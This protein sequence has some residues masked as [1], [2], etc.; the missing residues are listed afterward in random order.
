MLEVEPEQLS[1]TS[2]RLPQTGVGQFRIE[3]SGWRFSCSENSVSTL[4]ATSGA[5][6]MLQ[7]CTSVLATRKPSIRK[8]NLADDWVSL[9][10]SRSAAG[11]AKTEDSIVLILNH[12]ARRRAGAGA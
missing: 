5:G 11:E 7:I 10:N 1:E 8:F 9:E 2:V 3:C 6:T 12:C 4:L